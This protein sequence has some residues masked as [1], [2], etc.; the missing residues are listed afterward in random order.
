MRDVLRALLG[1]TLWI[2]G[3]AVPLGIAVLLLGHI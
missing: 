3:C 1:Y 2:A